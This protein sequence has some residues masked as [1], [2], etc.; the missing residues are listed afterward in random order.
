MNFYSDEAEWRYLFRKAVD[1]DTIVPLYYPTFPTADGFQNQ[2]EVIQFFE[3]L[4][5]ATGKWGGETVKQRAREL[6]EV[7][8]GK[9]VDGHVQISDVLKK[10]YGEAKELGIFGLCIDPEFGGM[11]APAT[12]GLLVFQ[13]LCRACVSTSTQ[14]GFFSSIADMIERFGDDETKKKYVPMICNA[15]ISGSMCMTE[16]DA[17]S[18]VGALRTSAEKQPNGTYLLN[19]TKSFITNGGGG[20]GFV[21]ARVKGAP[22]GLDGISMFFV[23][24]W[25]P[26]EQGAPKANYR[27]SKI[28]D[29][30]GMHGSPTCEVVYENSVGK[31]VGKENEGFKHMLFLMNA[32]RI[33]VGLQGLGGIEA[34]LST[35]REHAETRK[36]FGK[37]LVDLPLM[38]RNLQ[39]WETERDAF[40]ALMVDTV[41]YFDIFQKLDLKKRHTGELNEKETQLLSKA[42]KVVR[43]RTPLV[44]FY[45]AEA[46]VTLS[47][48]AIQ[49]FGGYGFMR[50]YDA[51]RIHRDSFG[52]LLY[53]GTSQIQSL[54]AMKDLVK[55]MTKNPTRFIQSLVANH[56]IR[57]WLEASE[58]DRSVKGLDYD[59]RKNVAGLVIRC[60]MPESKLADSGLMEK[61]TQINQV[62]K[63]EYWQD[64]TRFDK[65]M[66]HAETICQGLAYLETLK[67][68]ALHANRDAERGDLFHRYFKFV[69][70]KLI[71]IFA[72]WKAA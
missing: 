30:M 40:R 49:V 44:K 48:R 5:S 66:T 7:G 51:E 26:T 16:P 70:P 21:L 6:D 46:N 54:M 10:T 9:L 3:E 50:E 28:E 69:S 1:W 47:Q 2:E 64:V 39:D 57:A 24:E 13:Q 22:K 61:L 71:G 4:L 55:S 72:E 33:S 17:G 31:L 42:V 20:L 8:G 68:L 60:V 43:K 67:V 36:Q 37:T 23:E 34:A 38:K 41:S 52:A 29:K 14:I 62:L 15:E 65:L 35:A 58:F 56:P 11:G 27:I 53:E 18:D 45:G 12:I 19:G 32:A 59:F 25:L 63:Q